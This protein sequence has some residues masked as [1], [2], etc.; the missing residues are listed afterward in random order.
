[1]TLTFQIRDATSQCESEHAITKQPLPRRCGRI[2]ART[3]AYQNF[4][5]F[6]C[7]RAVAITWLHRWQERHGAGRL[8]KG[9][10]AFARIPFCFVR[11]D[12]LALLTWH[13]TGLA[14]QVC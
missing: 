5:V 8:D 6:R 12:C 13:W 3:A 9:P 1:M 14:V 11:R 4:I 7:E 10:R 2:D